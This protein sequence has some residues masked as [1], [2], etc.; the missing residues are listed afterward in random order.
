MFEI[1]NSLKYIEASKDDVLEIIASINI[2]LVAAADHPSEPTKAY[3]CSLRVPE[4]LI[5]VYIYLYLI[6]S[7]IGIIYKS[8]QGP[9]T[10]KDYPTM[11]SSA[12]E[13][14]E[15]MGF[16]MEDLTFG[17]LSEQ[18]KEELLSSLPLFLKDLAILKKKAEEEEEAVS[19]EEEEEEKEEEVAVSLEEVEGIPPEKEKVKEA[20]PKEEEVEEILPEVEEIAIAEEQEATPPAATKEVE[21]EEVKIEMEEARVEKEEEPEQAPEP[22]LEEAKIDWEDKELKQ[23]LEPIIRFLASI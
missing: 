13:F 21:E 20:L 19:L 2:P 6:Q 12:L 17:S 16:L 11:K 8:T 22:S 23:A 4:N 5:A 3:I 18:E 9:T 15:G 10:E 7:N 14:A 1:D